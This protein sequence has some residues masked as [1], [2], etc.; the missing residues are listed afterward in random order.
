MT[1]Y[2]IILEPP[3]L[4]IQ[5]SPFSYSV[6]WHY[7]QIKQY[8]CDI[9]RKGFNVCTLFLTIHSFF[10]ELHLPINNLKCY[11][12]IK[13]FYNAISRLFPQLCGWWILHLFHFNL[14]KCIT[15]LLNG[16]LFIYMYI[17]FRLDICSLYVRIKLFDILK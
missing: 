14:F 17:S 13:S 7:E 16:P 12:I 11:I 3:M 8:S 15:W 2:L 4:H 9:V 1:H 6:M 10:I 5:K